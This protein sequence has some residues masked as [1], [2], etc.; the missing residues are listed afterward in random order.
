MYYKIFQLT[1]FSGT[2]G[3]FCFVCSSQT[4]IILR[5]N[6]Q[7]I[8]KALPKRAIRQ[9]RTNNYTQLRKYTKHTIGTKGTAKKK[10]K[11]NSKWMMV[12]RSKVN[13]DFLLSWSYLVSH[14]ICYRLLTPPIPTI[15]SMQHCQNEFDVGK[16]L[17]PNMRKKKPGTLWPRTIR[18]HRRYLFMHTPKIL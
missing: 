11:K 16:I 1:R 8:L 4:S 10:K 3:F 12:V 18:W 9:T 13:A 7:N 5:Y 14:Y 17:I 2:G 6:S 15:T